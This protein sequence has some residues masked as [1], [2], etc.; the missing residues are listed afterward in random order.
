MEHGGV[1]V[2][3]SKSLA[4]QGQ[5]TTRNEESE[6]DRNKKNKRAGAGSAPAAGGALNSPVAVGIG[7]GAIVGVAAWALIRG[8]EPASP[9]K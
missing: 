3:T 1:T 7:T 5:E 8:D 4:T 9:V 6:K 2:S